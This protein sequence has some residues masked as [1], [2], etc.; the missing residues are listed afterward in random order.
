VPAPLRRTAVQTLGR[1]LP[2]EQLRA[3]LA[4]VLRA[5]DSTALRAVA[6]ETLA[7]HAPGWSCAE[8]MDQVALEPEGNRPA[9]E[10]AAAQ[11]EAGR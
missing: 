4:P 7:R 5:G 2:P 11:C 6:A 10:R 1:V 9:F 3:A 8:V